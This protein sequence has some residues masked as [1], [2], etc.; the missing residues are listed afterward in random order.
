MTSGP[1]QES[2]TNTREYLELCFNFPPHSVLSK[3]ASRYIFQLLQGER[4]HCFPFEGKKQ[5]M[6]LRDKSGGFQCQI[7]KWKV[8]NRFLKTIWN[9]HFRKWAICMMSS[10][11]NWNVCALALINLPHW[12]DPEA[13]LISLYL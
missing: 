5:K 8:S 3:E 13:F 7:C 12:L 4:P 1:M 6:L 10:T 9:I 2:Q 11:I